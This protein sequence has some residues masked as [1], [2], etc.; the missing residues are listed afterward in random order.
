M[1][2][3]RGFGGA[4]RRAS[5]HLDASREAHVDRARRIDAR[6]RAHSV[7]RRET[8]G[9]RRA[10]THE[11]AEG[12]SLAIHFSLDFLQRARGVDMRSHRASMRAIDRIV[13]VV[14]IGLVGLV[15]HAVGIA[16]IDCSD[17]S[18]QNVGLF[19]SAIGT[20]RTTFL[21]NY[22][23]YTPPT[24]GTATSIKA[25]MNVYAVNVVNEAKGTV[26]LIMT[27]SL[28][29]VDERLKYYTTTTQP[30]GCLQAPGMYLDTTTADL[31][32]RPA[33]AIANL[34][35]ST[36]LES[37]ELFVSPQG[38]VMYKTRQNVVTSCEF[39]FNKMPFD[40]Q[41]CGVRLQMMSPSGMATFNTEEVTFEKDADGYG[42]TKAWTFSIFDTASGATSDQRSYIDF[43]FQLKRIPDYWVTFTIAPSVMLVA[44]SYGTFWIQRT[45]MPAR[46]TFAFICYLTTISLTNGALAVL[47]KVSSRNVLLLNILTLGQ[48]FCA[49]TVFSIVVAN[50]LLHIEVRL[51]AAW[52]EARKQENYQQL[53]ESGEAIVSIGPR[54]AKIDHYIVNKRG[55][56]YFSDQHVDVL[57]RWLFPVAYALAVAIVVGTAL[58]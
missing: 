5:P 39:D 21:T 6:V 33:Y 58:E 9:A 20:V 46:A 43:G 30:T 50:Y 23:K 10:R 35:E 18:A 32:W 3:E 51:T 56:M 53:K 12:R 4:P 45:A 57:A 55:E 47:P 26:E 7:A 27:L 25:T 8:R 48:F 52:A 29:W 31:I 28:D 13:V 49:F 40:T 1:T 17:G 41:M 24:P 2:V 15:N 44:M 36:D 38:Q 42:G 16:A 37:T 19:S 11:G 22:D 34:Y 54:I 14:I